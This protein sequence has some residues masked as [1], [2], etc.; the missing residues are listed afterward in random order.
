MP[1]DL[2]PLRFLLDRHVGNAL[3][4]WLTE[5]GHDAFRASTEPDPGDDVL[6]ARAAA[7]ERVMVTIDKDFGRLIFAEGKKHSGLIRLPDVRV[8]ERIRLVELILRDNADDLRKKAIIT[9]RGGRIS[10]VNI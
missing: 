5:R 2:A 4:E 10:V 7:E 9:V 1:P 3:A 6:L 8:P